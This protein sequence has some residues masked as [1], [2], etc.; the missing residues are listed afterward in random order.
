MS[1]SPL[2][3]REIAPIIVTNG[4][5]SDYAKKSGVEYTVIGGE[6]AVSKELAKKYS[7][8]R[9]SGATRY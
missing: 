2:A 3:A 9:V 6:K 8:D 5:N 1:A 4:K 7:A